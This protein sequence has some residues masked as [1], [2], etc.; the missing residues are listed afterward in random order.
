MTF[1][2]YAQG[3]LQSQIQGQRTGYRITPRNVAG[4]CPKVVLKDI[5]PPW[6]GL[7]ILTFDLTFDLNPR[8]AGGLS[9]L[10]TAGGADTRPPQ[11]TRKLR[12]IATSGKRRWIGRLKFYKN[13]QNIFWSGQI[14]GRR[15]SE[16]SNFLKIG[17]FS[18][19]FAIT[20]KTIDS[21]Y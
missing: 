2:F 15:G 14:W 7:G 12:K 8:T 3:H 1:V 17:Q 16:R 20:S 4:S 11:R 18:Q 9:H 5:L 21:R 19:K 13:T 6:A 10:H